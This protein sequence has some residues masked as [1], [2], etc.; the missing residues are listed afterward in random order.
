MGYLKAVS[1]QVEEVGSC[2]DAEDAKLRNKPGGALTRGHFLVPTAFG[3]SL[4]R[5]T[6]FEDKREHTETRLPAFN[7]SRGDFLVSDLRDEIVRKS[8]YCVSCGVFS[9]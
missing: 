3:V 4:R 8:F 5:T 1:L 2:H 6:N 7:S 9:Q